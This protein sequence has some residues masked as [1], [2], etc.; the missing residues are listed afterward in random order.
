[1]VLDNTTYS[2]TE[3]NYIPIETD[4]T[5]IVIGH[6][7]NS[8]MKHFLGWNK[9][10]N[11]KYKKTAAFTIDAA[12]FVYKHFEPK[13]SSEFLDTDELNNKSIVIL[14]ENNGWLVKD[15]EKN[16]YITWIGN[17]YNKPI[18]ISE[19]RW[20]NYK[21]WDKYTDE[22]FESALELVNMLCEQ[23][24]IPK[25]V[26]AHNTKIDNFLDYKGV[27]YK[28]N[29]EKHYTDLSPSWNYEEFKHKLELI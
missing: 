14:L 5:Q 29:L 2:L 26:L 23:F 13:Y 20:R 16:E 10:Y 27:I 3:K 4:K 19:K 1:M 28:S 25:T 7:F 17:I 8:D 18:D 11:G 12:G 15:V 21:Y 22:Q 6:T 9:R 24:N